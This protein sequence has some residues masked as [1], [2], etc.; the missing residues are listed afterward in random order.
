MGKKPNL[1][2]IFPNLF[3]ASSAFIGILSILASI[4]GD[5]EKSIIYICLSLILDGLDGRV[6]RLTGTQSKFGVEFDSLA[7]IVAFGVAPAILFYNTIGVNFHKV[8]SLISAMFVVFGAIRLARFNVT[9][10]TY[11]PNVFIGLPIPTAAIT[12]AFWSGAYKEY[13]FFG[14]YEFLYLV[15]MGIL[16]L[17]MVSNI[18]FPSFKTINLKRADFLKVLVFFI[19]VLSLFYIFPYFCAL[20]LT[21]A[22]I[23]YGIV[24]TIYN[25]SIRFYKRSIK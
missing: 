19:I 4:K 15:F 16:S 9:T 14:G 23:I 10:G 2:Y 6:A 8:G 24:R 22:Y 20:I 18:R 5:Y 1:F 21:S 17:L 12:A 11:E 3:T 25:V 13:N 7:D